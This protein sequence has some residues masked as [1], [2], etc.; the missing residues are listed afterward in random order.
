METLRARQEAAEVVTNCRYVRDGNLVTA[1][2]ISAGIDM[3]L[4]LTGEIH[5]AD[6]ARIVC[7]AMEYDPGAHGIT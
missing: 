3:A 5:G 6:F 1:A 4:W 7:R 2:G